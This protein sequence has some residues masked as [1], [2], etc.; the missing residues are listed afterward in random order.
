[1]KKD[2]KP[3]YKAIPKKDKSKKDY[4]VIDSVV[5]EDEALEEMDTNV[6]MPKSP[7]NKR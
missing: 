3:K 7:F 1:M 2:K 5:I 6:N 4:K